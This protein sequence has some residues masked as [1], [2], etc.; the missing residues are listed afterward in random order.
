MSWTGVDW[1]GGYPRFLRD[2]TWDGRADIV[3]CGLNGVWVSR[4]DGHGN[5]LPPELAFNDLGFNQ[6]WRA[7]RHVRIMG[8]FGTTPL[9]VSV[10]LR[11]PALSRVAASGSRDAGVR[12]VRDHGLDIGIATDPTFNRPEPGLMG[13]GDQG[14]FATLSQGGGKFGPVT[15]VQNN[16]GFNQGWRVGQH[17]R[18]LADLNGNGLSDIIGFGDDGVWTCLCLGSGSGTIPAFAEGKFVLANFGVNQGWQGDRHPRALANLTG[19]RHADIV[20]FGDAGVWTSLGNGDGSFAESRF[21]LANLG[22]DQGWRVDQHP[23]FIADLTGDGRA[24]II[25]FGNDGVWTCLGNGDGSFAEAQFVLANLGFNQGWRV[26]QH[27]RFIADL[28]GDGHADIIG[29]GNDGVWTS[30]GNGDGSFAEAQFVL[31]NL[32]FN[33]GWRVDQHPR[34]LADITGDGRPDIVGF[35]DDGV[36]VALNNGDG[37]F[38]EAQF[39]LADFGLKSGQTGV[40]HVFVCMLE[41]RSYDHFLGLAKITGTDAFDGTQT[42]A[43]GLQGTETQSYEFQSFNVSGDATDR[44]DPGP[45]HNF[46]DFMVALCGPDFDNFNP[47]GGSYPAVNGTGYA[48]AYG[49]VTNKDSAGEVMKCFP[50]A[51]LQVLN[52]LANEFVVCDRWFGSLP[53]P[54]EPNRMFVHAASSDTWDDSPSGTDQFGAE[55]LGEDIG[56]D[57]GTIFDSLRNANVNFRIYAGDDFPNVA[58]L[59]GISVYSDI[60]D[61]EEF[62]GDLN[63]GYDAPYTFIEPNYAVVN[64]FDDKFFEGNSQHPSGSVAAGEDF[65]KSVY[66]AIRNSPVWNNSLLVVTWDEGGGFYDHVLPPRAVPTGKRGKTH[67]FMFDQLGSRVPAIIISPL[68]PKN[69]VE[70]RTLEHSVVLA[71]VQQVFGLDPLTDRDANFVGLQSLATLKTPRTD[72]PTTLPPSVVAPTIAA[73]SVSAA[74]RPLPADTRLSDIRD[75]NLASF[76]RSAVKQHMAAAPD[77]HDIIRARLNTLHTVDDYRQ[78]LREVSGIVKQKRAENRNARRGRRNVVIQNHGRAPIAPNL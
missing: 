10:D 22:F 24:D 65:I 8:D 3:G 35:G 52:A 59:H 77:Q 32:G 66:E 53:G 4:N 19:D 15:F 37:T 2:V 47:N 1:I 51:N 28:N 40:K 49:I 50:P 75:V 26:D 34:F 57:R 41:N 29:F 72:A 54:T 67:G 27:P 6:A 58:I 23:R 25:G 9:P 5:F 36:W 30:L 48:A 62:A 12:T 74:S 14:V 45:P 69:L 60:N 46:N 63:D 68:I 64:P 55:I 17:P 42:M 20:G 70:H 7:D 18:I 11:Q 39:V 61:F 43:D 13:F 56:F 78:Y 73:A 76:L 16:F 21:V 71:T 33:Q 38:A 31:A 44:I